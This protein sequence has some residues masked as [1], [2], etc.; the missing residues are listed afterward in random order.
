MAENPLDEL[1]PVVVDDPWLR[2]RLL[3]APSGEAFVAEVVGVA[4]GQGIDLPA[5]AVVEGLEAARRDRR[6]RWV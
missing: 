2:D 5:A 1:R 6:A 4:R 3:A